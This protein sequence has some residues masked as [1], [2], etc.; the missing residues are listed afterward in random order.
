[1]EASGGASRGNARTR[2]TRRSRGH[3]EK[4][5]SGSL[6]VKVYAGHDELLQRSLCLQ[7]TVSM[8]SDEQ[9]TWERAKQ[10]WGRIPRKSMYR[11][12]FA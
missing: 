1:M 3:I 6:R 9:E 2:P 12:L 5:K 4:L 10:L 8:G 11:E 7:E